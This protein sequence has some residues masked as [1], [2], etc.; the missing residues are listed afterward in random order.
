[1]DR[2]S[3]YLTAQFFVQALTIFL[4]G[5]ALIWLMQLLRLF[6]LVSSQGQNILTLMGQSALTTPTYARSILYVCLAIGLVRGLRAL[7]SSRELHTIH[8]A[9]R[10]PA[11]WSAIIAFTVIGTLAV[12]AVAHWAE[13]LAR[14]VSAEWS[15]DIAADV[16]GRA[17]VPGQFTELEDGLVFSIGGRRA[18]GT[19]A[20]FF[21]DDTT[22]DTRRTYFAETA[23]VFKDTSGY[24]LILN[25]GAIQYESAEQRGLSQ[26]A[27]GQ[28]HIS[29]TSLVEAGR[30]DAGIE[31][32]DT[33]ALIEGLG[34]GTLD[35]PERAL[36][37]VHSRLADGL[38]AIAFCAL[39][40]SLVAFP[41]GRRGGFRVPMELVIL[42]IAFAEQA[43]SAFSGGGANHYVA[44][45]LILAFAVA[46]F[47]YRLRYASP[48]SMFRRAGA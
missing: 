48:P 25:D 35:N 5:G 6:D 36:A 37:A 10:T 29:L 2:L 30:P 12:G 31:Q 39:A 46:L 45:G 40:A 42:V 18:D 27:F 33:L 21:F 26:I 14:R 15:A 24:Q 17:L 23:R 9:Q 7:Q 1:M 3:R 4:A 38:R 34:L 28:Y 13:P 41:H 47:A 44:P 32:L 20:D 11:L 43:V 22:H 8:A 16:V 19:L